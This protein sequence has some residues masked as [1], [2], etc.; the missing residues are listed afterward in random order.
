MALFDAIEGLGQLSERDVAGREEAP[1]VACGEEG[2]AV[3]PDQQPRRGER[4]G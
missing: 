3:T 1:E 2:V 4:I